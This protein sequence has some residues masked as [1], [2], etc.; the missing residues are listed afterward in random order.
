MKLSFRL[1]GIA[2]EK[3]TTPAR[4]VAWL[5]IAAPFANTKIGKITIRLV[6][7]NVSTEFLLKIF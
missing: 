4:V 7:I 2:V 5:G 3:L 6:I 1:A